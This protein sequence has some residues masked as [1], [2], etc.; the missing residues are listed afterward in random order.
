[1]KGRV[2]EG[3][4][5]VAG[6]DQCWGTKHTKERG[7][8]PVMYVCHVFVC[9]GCGKK[10]KTNNSI[11][12]HKKLFGFKPHHR[13]GFFNFSMWGLGGGEEMVGSVQLQEEGR[14]PL[15]S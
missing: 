7:F 11:N 6:W 1:M 10:I 12:R 8:I 15:P 13:K 9:K 4:H 5:V 14:H 2:C 3:I